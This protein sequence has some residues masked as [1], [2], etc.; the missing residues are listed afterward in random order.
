M[1]LLRLEAFQNYGQPTP[2]NMDPVVFVSKI[3]SLYNLQPAFFVSS[4]TLLQQKGEEIWKLLEQGGVV[5]TC[6]DISVNLSIRDALVKLAQVYGKLGAFQ[7][8]VCILLHLCFLFCISF[9]II[10]DFCRNGW[11]SYS[12]RGD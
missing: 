11:I 4:L 2:E 12:R 1:R 8:H 5:Y 10:N 6:G 3:F 9:A 7:A